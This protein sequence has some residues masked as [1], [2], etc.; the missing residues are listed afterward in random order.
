MLKIVVDCI[1][2]LEVHS[3]QHSSHSA[4]ECFHATNPVIASSI[5][6]FS[7][8][9]LTRHREIAGQADAF[10]PSSAINMMARMKESL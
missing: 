6:N 7:C 10:V 4:V 2:H 1:Y 5:K 9:P 8:R 3:L